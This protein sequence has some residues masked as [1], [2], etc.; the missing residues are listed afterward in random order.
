MKK[1]MSINESVVDLR[2]NTRKDMKFIESHREFNN[3]IHDFEHVYGKF[4]YNPNLVERAKY[5]TDWFSFINYIA[6]DFSNLEYPPCHLYVNSD[7]VIAIWFTPNDLVITG[8][9]KEDEKTILT[10][11]E[12][13]LGSL[14]LCTLKELFASSGDR[15]I[16][17]ELYLEEYYRRNQYKE[18][19][20]PNPICESKV[21]IES[22]KK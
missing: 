15:Q 11:M 3:K 12:H 22:E 2:S 14:S 7:E 1:C 19:L 6:Y 8:I 16:A 17:E 5:E 18:I 21:G 10:N 9:N 4:N 20:L 13:Q